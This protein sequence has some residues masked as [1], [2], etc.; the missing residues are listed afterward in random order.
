MNKGITTW[1]KACLHCQR[2]KIAQHN[3]F[4]P[5]KLRVP[6]AWFQHVHLDIIGPLP[7]AQRFKYCLTLIDR[8]SRWPQTIP[9][10][11]ISADTI[12]KHFFTD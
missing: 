12:A 5:E 1:V 6:D 9:L 10:L 8:F 2:A 11:D 3:Y 7:I 4:V